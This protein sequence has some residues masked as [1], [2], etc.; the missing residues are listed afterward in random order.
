MGEEEDLKEG[1]EKAQKKLNANK[2]SSVVA[3]LCTSMLYKA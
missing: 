2:R 3:E 1:E